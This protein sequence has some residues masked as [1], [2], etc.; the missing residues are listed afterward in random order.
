M[1]RILEAKCL[2]GTLRGA[3][4]QHSGEGNMLNSFTPSGISTA[5]GLAKPLKKM[6]LEAV[7]TFTR[8]RKMRLD[9]ALI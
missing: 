4:A 7:R 1:P 8:P 2:A 9:L 5:S 6:P 3:A